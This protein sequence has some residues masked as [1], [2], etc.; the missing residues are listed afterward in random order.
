[1]DITFNKDITQ[2]FSK[3][4]TREWLETNGLGGWASSTIS[5]CNTRNYHGMLVVATKPPLGRMVMVSKLEEFIHTPEGIVELQCNQFPGMVKDQALQYLVHYQQAPFPTFQY[6]IGEIELEK[7]IAAIH[8]KDLVVVKYQVKK[9]P[10][11]FIMDLKPLIAARDYHSLSKANGF[12]NQ[13]VTFGNGSLCLQPYSDLPPIYIHAANSSFKYKPDWYLN[14]EYKEE[15]ARGLAFA[16]D[17]FTYG[18]LVVTLKEGQTF[19]VMLSTATCEQE[20][21]DAL[22]QAEKQRREALLQQV[23]VQ[24][25]LTKSLVLAADQFVVKRGELSTIIAGYHWFSDWGRDTMI[26]LPG[27]CL[28]TKKYNEAR[29]ILKAFARY[30]NQGLIPNRFPDQGEVPEYNTV[31]ATL[32][33]FVAAKKYL[34]YTGDKTFIL[35]ELYTSLKDSVDWHEK[36]THYSIHVEEDGLLYAGEFGVQLTWMDAKIGNWVVTPRMG[37]PVEINALWY[38]VL[39]I[40]AEFAALKGDESLRDSYLKKADK[41]KKAFKETFWIADKGYLYDYVNLYEQN[42]DIR[43]NQIMALSLPYEL[44]DKTSAMSVLRTVEEHLLTPFGL[45]SL[46]PEHYRYESHYS[47]NQWSRDGAYHQGTVWSWLLGPYITAKVRLEGDAGRTI[48]ERLLNSFQSHLLDAGL[49]T[50]SE[51]FDGESPHYPKGC[52]AQAWGVA[53]VLRAYLEDVKQA[54]R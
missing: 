35:D 17:L 22:L 45:R 46:S 47:G 1:M 3:A 52:V 13:E 39:M 44:L 31:D 40:M 38:N 49:G 5:G 43:P 41:V 37:K 9:A 26:S 29:N 18:Q 14:F 6:K 33:F 53:E 42:D 34:D 19:Y 27:I 12:I 28:V 54:A 4:S 20:Q 25:N 36:G 15:Q 11:A 10:Q 8:G 7:T 50:V 51:I 32:W 48:V 2:H 21:G 16:E 24:T 23:S 30:M